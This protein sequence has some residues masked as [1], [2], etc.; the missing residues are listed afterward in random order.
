MTQFEQMDL[1]A[2]AS[3]R[4]KML[5]EFLEARETMSASF[6]IIQAEFGPR[7]INIEEAYMALREKRVVFT[8]KRGEVQ[9][10]IYVR[11]SPGDWPWGVTTGEEAV[12]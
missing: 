5:Y 4:E 8:N 11:D 6:P 2:G 9:I 7:C 1:P 3:V 12:L 10:A